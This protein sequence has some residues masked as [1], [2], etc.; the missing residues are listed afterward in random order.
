MPAGER[1]RA[2]RRLAEN[3]R[4]ALGPRR[5]RHVA[6][7]LAGDGELDPLP[8]LAQARFQGA[9]LYLPALDRVHRGRMHFR[10]W[11]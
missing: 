8:A 9:R 4:R 10:L 7:Y 3:L 5:V 6:L 2:Q 1:R 11:R